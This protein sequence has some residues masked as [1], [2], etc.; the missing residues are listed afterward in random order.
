MLEILPRLVNKINKTKECLFKKPSVDQS[1]SDL[2]LFTTFGPA[3]SSLLC[4]EGRLSF[5]F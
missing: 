4:S 1:T 5:L 2:I 3:L